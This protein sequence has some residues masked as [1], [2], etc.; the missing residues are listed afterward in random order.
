MVKRV[1][2]A[3]C[4][5]C[6]KR[7]FRSRSEARKRAKVVDRKM[8]AYPCPVVTHL[9]HLGHLPRSVVHGQVTRG[10]IYRKDAA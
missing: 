1:F 3:T 9:W 6:N 8:N 7:W 10:Q 5:D 2:V 4:N